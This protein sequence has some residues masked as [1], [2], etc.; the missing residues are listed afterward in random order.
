MTGFYYTVTQ[1]LV[2]MTLSGAGRWID[3]GVHY[4]LG[5]MGGKGLGINNKEGCLSS[6]VPS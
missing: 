3:V 2:V 6:L 5:W 1:G 4:Y